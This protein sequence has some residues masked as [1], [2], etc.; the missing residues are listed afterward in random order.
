MNNFQK[1][2]A[3]LACILLFMVSCSD[4]L[5][6]EPES[7]Y[8]DENFFLTTEHAEMALYGVYNSLTS[9]ELY[10][11]NITQYYDIDS[12][13][14]QIYGGESTG[15]PDGERR[16]IARYAFNAS[17]KQLDVA[18]NACY[19]GINRANVLI[20][21]VPKMNL[22]ENGT[23]AEKKI[24][25]RIYGEGLTLRA[26]FY[27]DLIRLWGDVPFKTTPSK[28]GENFDLPRTSRDS[29]Y[30][31]II[32]DLTNAIELV[33]WAD[34]VAN[35]ERI[36]RGAVKGIL[37]RI[38]LYAAGYSLR[39]DLETGNINTL[40]MAT[41]DDAERIKAL[42]VIARDQCADIIAKGIHR[43]NPSYENLWKN[44]SRDMIDNE[45]K[46]NIFELG[47]F[48]KLLVPDESG[49]Y[50]A[51]IGI[52][53]NLNSKWGK[54]SGGICVMPH[55][56]YLF[57]NGD[58]RRD[59]SISNYEF[60]TASDLTLNKGIP[61]KLFNLYPAKW[62]KTWSDLPTADVTNF[63]YPMLRYSDVLLM[64]A[65]SDSRIANGSTPDA[66]QALK[67]VR[68]RAMPTKISQIDSETYPSDFEGF[69]D[70]IIKERAFELAF[71]GFRKT[72]LIR[73]NKLASAIEYTRTET[74]AIQNCFST[75]GNKAYQGSII[76]LQGFIIPRNVFYKHDDSKEFV[77]IDLS[78]SRPD[79]DWSS[80]PWLNASFMSN[81]SV[82]ATGFRENQS[83][84][85]P[86]PT[87]IIDNSPAITQLPG[88]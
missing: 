51:Y 38:C 14:A 33:P 75:S 59:V 23:E 61:C 76:H 4:F 3:I 6:I 81:M 17:T 40:K 42:Y 47:F 62:R 60:T 52:R 10:G 58:T 46:E 16:S 12:D 45:Y 19:E 83:E 56:Y 72:D 53:S 28:H 35:E 79:A 21:R 20:D 25:K 86:I 57:E 30:D 66:I 55:F 39:W 63:N 87:K 50:G 34:E 64:F 31:Y 88:Y 69:L 73:W 77:Q 54:C 22:Y 67:M 84:L 26:I 82:Y 13:I 7:Q 2:F 11:R 15:K 71:E 68:K 44:V 9:T 65:E 8:M 18:W 1:T 80:S 43:L 74:N 41:R 85:F 36:T 32:N 70:V 78:G 27:F 49:Y 48:S 5:D 37:A 29:I 24:L